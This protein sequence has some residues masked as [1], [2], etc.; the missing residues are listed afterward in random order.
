MAECGRCYTR[1]D[2]WSGG[3]CSRCKKILCGY[4]LYGGFWQRLKAY[5]GQDPVCMRC[6]RPKTRTLFVSQER[7]VETPRP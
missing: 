1:F 5:F 7:E 6:R 4:H 2:Q 3:V